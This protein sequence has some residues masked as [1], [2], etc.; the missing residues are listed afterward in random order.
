MNLVLHSF[1]YCLEF[2]REQI[3]D[4][5]PEDM[6]AQPNGIMNHPAWVL[7]HMTF[8]C[9]ALGGELGMPPWLPQSFAERFGTGS[10]PLADANAYEQKDEA[11]GMLDEAEN[12]ITNAVRR[13]N[14]SQLEEPLPDEKYRVLLPTIGHAI[15]Q[16]LTAHS[17]NHVGQ[18]TIWR[19]AMDLPR[20]SRPFL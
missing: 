19:Q 20:V 11:L 8:S 9:Q 1:A 6:T 16:V 2:L 14:D 5:V 15:T 3:A 4:V 10:V 13:L 12:R 7:G 17:A 18:M